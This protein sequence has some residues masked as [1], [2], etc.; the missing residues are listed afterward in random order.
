MYITLWS[1][2]QMEKV[3]VER[4]G[5]WKPLLQENISILSKVGRFIFKVSLMEGVGDDCDPESSI[6]FGPQ[7]VC[8][9]LLC[10]LPL[11]RSA[12]VQSFWE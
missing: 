6:F 4:L 12:N 11:E 9:V 7:S 8:H 2:Y 5:I 3:Q 1:A 10:A